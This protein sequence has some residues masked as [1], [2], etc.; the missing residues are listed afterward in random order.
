MHARERAG[1][2]EGGWELACHT[3]AAAAAACA[4]LRD[5][6]EATSF[7]LERRQCAL[8]CVAQE[9]AGLALRGSPPYAL[10]Y[11]PTAP[12]LPLPLPGDATPRHR[13]AV[14]REEGSNG[15]REMSAAFVMAG[16]EVSGG[17][18]CARTPA[19]ARSSAPPPLRTG[20]QV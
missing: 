20:L 11:E 7:E 3:A 15:D 14:L 19:V 13:V 8:E 16:F 10:T 9:Q 18:G 12:A 2:A 1:G 5:T 6:W 17:G 4:G